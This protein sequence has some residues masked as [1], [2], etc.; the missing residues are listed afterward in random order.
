MFVAF[1]SDSAR[2]VAHSS[3]RDTRA[4]SIARISRTAR[5]A[6]HVLGVSDFHGA[7]GV[8][9][10]DVAFARDGFVGAIDAGAER[11]DGARAS[12][13]TKRAAHARHQRGVRE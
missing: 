6:R 10:G 1:V 3:A 9:R 12:A 13:A 5:L 11:V 8:A 4:P 7:R 2:G